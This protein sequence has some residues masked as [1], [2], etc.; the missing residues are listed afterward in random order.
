MATLIAG[1][2]TI[3]EFHHWYDVVSGA[4]IG[5]MMA[6]GAW[7]FVWASVWGPNNHV[8]LVRDPRFEVGDGGVVTRRWKGLE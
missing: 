1:S 8:P 4:V 2:L 3:D 5:T 7:R 6:F